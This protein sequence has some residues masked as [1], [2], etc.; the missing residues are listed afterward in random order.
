LVELFQEL[1]VGINAVAGLE[2]LGLLFEQEGA[3]LPFGQTAA[4][5]EKG[6]VLLPLSAVAV[7]VATFEKALEKGSVNCIGW[8]GE[9]AQEMSLALTQG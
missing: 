3:H 1:L 6:A 5:V 9:C 8:E 4:E 7:G 2:D